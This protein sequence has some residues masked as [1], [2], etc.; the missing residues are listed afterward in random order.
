[1]AQR[2]PNPNPNPNPYQIGPPVGPVEGDL[3]EILRGLPGNQ[4]HGNQGHGNQ[5]HGNQGHGNQGHGNQ[6]HGNQGHGNQGNRFDL[7]GRIIEHGNQG[8]RDLAIGHGNQ[9]HGNQGHGNQGHGFDLAIVRG[10]QGHINQAAPPRAAQ[11]GVELHE[12][13]IRQLFVLIDDNNNKKIDLVELSILFQNYLIN[14]INGNTLRIDQLENLETKQDFK[15]YFNRYDANRDGSIDMREF[16]IMCNQFHDKLKK[17]INDFFG[18]QLVASN[19]QQQQVQ[20]RERDNNLNITGDTPISNGVTLN[21]ILQNLKSFSARELAAVIGR[22]AAKRVFDE[23]AVNACREVHREI[24]KMRNIDIAIGNLDRLVGGNINTN[25]SHIFQEFHDNLN[26][27]IELYL[28]KKYHSDGLEYTKDGLIMLI[29]HLLT[30]PHEGLKDVMPA[31]KIKENLALSRV[32]SLINSYL[33]KIKTLGRAGKI[34]HLWYVMSYLNLAVSGYG[35]TIQ[36]FIT[37][38]GSPRPGQTF[39][40]GCGPGNADRVLLAL[41][42][43]ISTGLSKISSDPKIQ[44]ARILAPGR[45]PAP[46]PRAAPPGGGQNGDVF[47]D[48]LNVLLEQGIPFDEAVAQANRILDAPGPG[49]AALRR[50]PAPRA[51]APGRGNAAPPGGGRY[52]DVFIDMLNGFM[53]Q[54]LSYDE[55]EA[56]ANRILDAAPAPRGNPAQAPRGNPAPAQAQGNP[57]CFPQYNGTISP[58]FN[59]GARLMDYLT[60]YRT[61]ENRTLNGFKQVLCEKAN[62]DGNI[63]EEPAEFLQI[64][65][66]ELYAP[67]T[68]G[69]GNT[70]LVEEFDLDNPNCELWT[71][72]LREGGRKTKNR[73]NNKNKKNKKNKR[74]TKKNNF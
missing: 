23:Q 14:P 9:G 18:F 66:T 4:R 33:T 3:E 10:N 21:S 6:R 26:Y 20:V 41:R 50:G 12:N 45:A 68:S 51:P 61:S 47:I 72:Q 59:N 17:A 65:A 37:G 13:V 54:G 39:I 5:G 31:F 22:S 7:V 46:A 28:S 55:A 42:S 57:A 34:L 32:M 60:K 24:Q 30:H 11:G 16:I 58:T 74:N 63:L 35:H 64:M 43:S 36:T 19:V 29:R 15:D 56:Q 69:M 44:Q 67:G 48:M 38:N 1:M 62:D 27:G 53:E 49:N 40:T 25:L 73:K 2:N 71:T 70:N 8:Q 52:E